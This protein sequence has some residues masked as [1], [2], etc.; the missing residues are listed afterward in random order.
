[1]SVEVRIASLLK[2]AA[3]DLADARSLAGSG[4]RNA[5]FLLEQSAEK[6]IRAVLTSE[7]IHPGIKHEL[8]KMVD[9]VPDA[10][11]LKALLRGIEHLG[12][13]ATSFRYPTAEGKILPL[14]PDIGKSIDAVQRALDEA[15]ARFGVDLTSKD[16]K[17]TR[18]A[19]V[20]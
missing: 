13:F 11:P 6:I 15:A 10:N 3:I 16:S 1:M 20:R 8:D 19:P 9:A 7:A 5:A 2:V 4:S 18:P 17:A 14:P 12:R